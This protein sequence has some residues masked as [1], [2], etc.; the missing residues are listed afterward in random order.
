MNAAHTCPVPLALAA[1]LP[2]T[3]CESLLGIDS[4]E[5]KPTGY[6]THTSASSGNVEVWAVPDTGG[7]PVC[8]TDGLGLDA[9][10]SLCEALASPDGRRVAVAAGRTGAGEPSLDRHLWVMDIDGTNAHHVARIQIGPGFF[11]LSWYPDS[12]RLLFSDKQSCSNN[13]LRVDVDVRASETVVYDVD[14]IAALPRVNPFDEDQV[15]FVDQRCG[16]GG[17]RRSLTLSSAAVTSLANVSELD[18]DYRFTRWS[19]DGTRLASSVGG[20]FVA[21]YGV[22][23][24]LT[25]FPALQE[26]GSYTHPMFGDDESGLHAR[27]GVPDI[28]EHARTAYTV[29]WAR[30]TINIDADSD[31]LAWPGRRVLAAVAHRTLDDER[32]ANTHRIPLTRARDRSTPANH[33]LREPAR[34]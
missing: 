27:L 2:T 3:G 13:I 12:Q 11:G 7:S 6:V 20:E 22:A 8:L 18:G 25:M 4:G 21:I 26:R 28:F 23:G 17:T 14:D 24:G 5:S 1:L 29:G 34:H 33:R 32:Y 31:G 19:R 16:E 30:Y 9:V 15:L 10:S